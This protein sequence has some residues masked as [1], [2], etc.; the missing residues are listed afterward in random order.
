MA[1]KLVPARALIRELVIYRDGGTRRLTA[2]G[3][4]YEKA[5]G[6]TCLALQHPGGLAAGQLAKLPAR[7]L[8]GL[9]LRWTL[10]RRQSG[11]F[12]QYNMSSCLFRQACFDGPAHICLSVCSQICSSTGHSIAS[13]RCLVCLTAGRCTH[14]IYLPRPELGVLLSHRTD[15]RDRNNLVDGGTYDIWIEQVVNKLWCPHGY[16]RVVA[17]D[18]LYTV[19]SLVVLLLPS[20]SSCSRRRQRR[21]CGCELTIGRANATPS[22][23]TKR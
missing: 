19:C 12:E 6:V 14:S 3:N 22:M 9:A 2:K 7:P 23:K 13:A 1:E 5:E 11:V 4:G 20:E 10:Q 17:Q 21:G 8:S 16:S 15:E 18:C